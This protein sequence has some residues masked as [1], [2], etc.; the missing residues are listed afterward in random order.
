MITRVDR[1]ERSPEAL[2]MGS[3]RFVEVMI[4]VTGKVLACIERFEKLSEV[5]DC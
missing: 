3:M 4:K 5:K 1:D 2:V